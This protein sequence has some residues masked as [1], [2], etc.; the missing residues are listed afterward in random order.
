MMVFLLIVIYISFI[1]VGLPDSVF[2]TAWPAIYSDLGLPV[3]MQG[4]VSMTTSACTT[5]SGLCSVK[6]IEKFGTGIVTSVSTA[7]TVA[8]L[9]GMAY[10]QH[11]IFFFLLAIP[12]GFGAGAVDSGLNNYVALHYSAAQMNFLHCFYGIG[13]SVSPYLLSFA[14]AGENGWRGGYRI[15]ALAQGCIAL[16]TI[17]SLP[18]WRKANRKTSVQDDAPRT[19]SLVQML[20]IPAVRLDCLAFLLSCAVE[21]VAGTWSS[22]FFVNARGLEP[23][24]AAKIT[25]LFYVGLALSRFFSGVLAKKL[26]SWQMIF[27]SGGIICAA[28][29]GIL[30]PLPVGFSACALFLI[31][32]GIGPIFPNLTHLAPRNFGREVSGS[33][34]GLQMAASSAGIMMMPMIFGALVQTFSARV[35]PYYLIIAFSL[36]AIVLFRFVKTLKKEKSGM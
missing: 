36:Y 5:V 3:S 8:G 21:V 16:V 32:F 20:K 13:V 35:F 24:E 34:I 17:L 31:G 7:L 1:G 30:L 15:V 10:V 19:L 28:I 12:L 6:V 4:F 2:G 22:T 25:M 18:L 9:F 23:D 29:I 14:L 26:T 33:I 11:P 27:I